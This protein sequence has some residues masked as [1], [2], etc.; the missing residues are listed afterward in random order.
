MPD[1]DNHLTPFCLVDGESTAFSVEI[2][3]TKTLDHPKGL[4]KTK[5]SPDFDDIVA[6]SLTLWRVSIPILPK[7]ERKDTLPADV[8]SKEE[9]EEADDISE[10]FTEPPRKKT[11]HIIV[12]RPPPVHAPI[13]TRA[14]TPHSDNSRPSGLR[15]DIKKITDR[16]FATG[17]PASDF[18]NA[19]VR[20]E[21][22]LPVTTVELGG[23]PKSYGEA[24]LTAR[25]Q[26]QLFFF[27]IYQT[28]R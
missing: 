10:V 11:I 26:D 12:Q 17:S 28:L 25:I 5:Q 19:Y 1:G 18:L 4:I 27:W 9:L 23:Y 8:P 22:S 14:P 13:P 15:A 2:D 6:K 21:K 3:P 24:L 16:F 7:K 20:G